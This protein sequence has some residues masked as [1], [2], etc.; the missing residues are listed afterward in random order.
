MWEGR[1]GWMP[2]VE[3]EKDAKCKVAEKREGVGEKRKTSFQQGLSDNTYETMRYQI[4]VI[5]LTD[6]LIV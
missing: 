4:S 5:G 6:E 3:T 1:E 2:C